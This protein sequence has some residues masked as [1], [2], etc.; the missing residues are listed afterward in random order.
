MATEIKLIILEREPKA[1]ADG[2][3]PGI[4]HV[5]DRA[6]PTIERGGTY[7]SLKTGDYRMEHSW[8]QSGRRVKCLRP[9]EPN[10]AF[11]RKKEKSVESILIHD[12]FKDNS[13]ELEGCISP[14]MRKKPGRGMGILDAAEAMEEIWELLGGFR[15]GTEITLH[16]L[17]NV[18][19]DS[20]TKE[21]WDRVR[22]LS[23]RK[24]MRA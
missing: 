4:L 12:A 20:Q 14:G 18:P 15:E 1:H 21:T 9:I 23:I 2:S 6:F 7:V 19:D 13:T 16:V 5:G 10:K 17:N 3:V 8:K 22:N 24:L 11:L